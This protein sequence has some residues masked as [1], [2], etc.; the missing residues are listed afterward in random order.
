[1]FQKITQFFV[2]SIVFFLFLVNLVFAED[3]NYWHNT[4]NADNY[5]RAIR[6][7]PTTNILYVGGDF[8]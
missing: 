8:G 6:V 2:L 4:G 7:E 3:A 5:V 1:M